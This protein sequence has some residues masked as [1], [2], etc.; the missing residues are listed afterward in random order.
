MRNPLYNVSVSSLSRLGGQTQKLGQLKTQLTDYN[1]K[2]TK[3]RD[4][5]LNGDIDS[6]DYHLIKRDSER[7]ITILEAKLFDLSRPADKLTTLINKA[8]GTLSRLSEIYQQSVPE[9]KR[10]LISSMYPENLTF[11]GTQHR[12]TRLNEAIRVFDI[13]KAIIE[14]KKEGQITKNYDLPVMVAGSRIELPT[15]GL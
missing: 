9:G 2:I 13:M 11:D 12:T 15:S 1:T 7:H 3:A 14:S 10:R 6:A 8:V 5:L 4:L